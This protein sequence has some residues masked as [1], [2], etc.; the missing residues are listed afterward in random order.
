MILPTNCFQ[1]WYLILFRHQFCRHVE[2][3]FQVWD[4]SCSQW[5]NN[6]FLVILSHEYQWF[7]VTA[8]NIPQIMECSSPSRVTLEIL[9]CRFRIWSF[10]RFT[11]DL[12]SADNS[13][14]FHRSQR[15]FVE[16]LP[17]LENWY[18]VAP[19]SHEVFLRS[20]RFRREEFPHDQVEL[21]VSFSKKFC[22]VVPTGHASQSQFSSWED[23]ARSS[24]YFE[25][26]AEEKLSMGWSW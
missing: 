11:N 5:N 16:V 19:I 14:L 4:L 12:D 15:R 2:H 13:I 8:T 24:S 20:L 17:V 9:F 25:K 22:Q 21:F 26:L 23:Q 1:S 10:T 7:H 3:L 6:C 18:Q